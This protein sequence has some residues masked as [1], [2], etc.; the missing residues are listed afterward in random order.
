MMTPHLPAAKSPPVATGGLSAP[1][2]VPTFTAAE[3]AP[4]AADYCVC[5]FVINEN[6]KLHKQLAAMQPHTANVDV[7]IADGG[8]TDGSTDHEK[9]RSLGVNTLLTK[10]GPGKLGAQMRMAFAWALDRGYK[11]V[12]CIDGNGKD[13]PDA[14][15]RFVE[16][17]E[18]GYDH[19]H[20]SRF[21]AGG[22]CEDLPLSRWLGLK[23]LH[24]PLTSLPS[25]S[26]YSD[27]TRRF[28]T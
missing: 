13:G 18:E 27:T 20:G 1:R 2:Q 16:K 3:F 21:L 7:V 10:T 25:R 12:V 6:G 5:V 22:V 9:L 4:R 28:R 19:V 11:G 8:S 24:A 15:P 23:V 14:I 26:S 17:L